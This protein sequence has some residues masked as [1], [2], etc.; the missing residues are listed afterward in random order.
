[1]NI[2]ELQLAEKLAEMNGKYILAIWTDKA[3]FVSEIG[4]AHV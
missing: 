1:M 2:N 3:D 4:R